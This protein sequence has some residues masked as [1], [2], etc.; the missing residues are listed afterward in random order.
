MKFREGELV[1]W[2]FD[3]PDG[4]S[5]N[6]ISETK[7]TVLNCIVVRPNYMKNYSHQYN[8]YKKTDCVQVVDV[9]TQEGEVVTLSAHALTKVKNH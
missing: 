1:E 8:G 3:E 5:V 9:L 4:P 6:G 2:I 7:I